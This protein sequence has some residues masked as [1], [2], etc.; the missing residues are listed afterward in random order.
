M[1]RKNHL[2][3]RGGNRPSLNGDVPQLPFIRGGFVGFGVGMGFYVLPRVAFG[4]RV[5]PP[6]PIYS[7]Y[8]Y[9][10]KLHGQNF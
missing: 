5:E 3:P 4:F 8:T 2:Q 6:C 7:I 1:S 9:L 10:A